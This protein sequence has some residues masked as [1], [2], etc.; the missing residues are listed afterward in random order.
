[1]VCHFN[2]LLLST[3]ITDSHCIE[4]LFAM[5]QHKKKIED[6]KKEFTRAKESFDR[7]IDL[8]ILQTVHKIGE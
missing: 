6:F 1:M 5:K 4:Q 8:E 7:G 2:T 3:S